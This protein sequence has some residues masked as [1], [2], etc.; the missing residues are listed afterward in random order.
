MFNIANQLDDQVIHTSN[1]LL[2]K[3]PIISKKIIAIAKSKIDSTIIDPKE[4]LT[5][6][7]RETD[8]SN[9]TDIL[10]NNA[11]LNNDGE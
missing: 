10:K 4:V 3:W 2:L 11:V 9:L 7:W 5:D 1:K 6:E 8:Y